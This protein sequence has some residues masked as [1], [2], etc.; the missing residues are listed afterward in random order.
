[1]TECLPATT[2]PDRLLT[3][4][5]VRLLAAAFGAAISFYHS[6]WAP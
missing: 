3:P 4:T 5:M 1:M 2:A 6:R